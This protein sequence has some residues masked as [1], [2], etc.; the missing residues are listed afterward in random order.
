MEVKAI[1]TT[2]QMVVTALM[3]ALVF[4]AGSVI[5][6]PT[7]GG[8]IHIGDCMIFLSVMI[9]GKKRGAL[10][11][12]IGMFLVDIIAGY[13]IWAP[14]TFAIKFIM[15]YISGAIIERINNNEIISEFKKRYILAFIC[16]GLFMIIGYFIAG[17]LIAG[18]F[19]S[20]V[21]IIQGLIISAKDIIGN[22][23]QVTVGIVLSV[24]LSTII[25]RAKNKIL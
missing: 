3:I 19:T 20:S 7:I 11:S 5:K 25:L 4:L 12:G 10:A 21:G 24:P 2:R 16:G 6:I 15:A 23:I 22:V 1:R 9:L 14:F 17:A 13:Y 8:F 18:L